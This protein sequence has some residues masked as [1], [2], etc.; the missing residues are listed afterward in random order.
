M[1]N[2]I[3]NTNAM[4]AL[5][6][7]PHWSSISIIVRGAPGRS[8]RRARARLRWPPAASTVCSSEF[9]NTATLHRY[10]CTRRSIGRHAKS[11][12]ERNLPPLTALTQPASQRN[13]SMSILSANA[14]RSP[15]FIGLSTP[16][17]SIGSQAYA[18]TNRPR[19]R[20]LAPHVVLR[21]SGRE[22]SF[23]HRTRTVF[24]WAWGPFWSS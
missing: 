22:S 21:Y 7:H 20:L 19:Q 14:M 13:T 11:A 9:C 4:C 12:S 5:F 18:A 23:T 10:D 8:L 6:M 24:R 17:G 15:A 2:A 16:K 1:T 3:G